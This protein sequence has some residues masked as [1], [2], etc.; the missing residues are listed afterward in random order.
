LELILD[1]AGFGNDMEKAGIGNGSHRKKSLIDLGFGCGDQIIHLISNELLRSDDVD[2]HRAVFSHYVGVTKDAV[3]AR[4]ASKRVEELKW[5][6]P[7]ASQEKQN[8]SITL[9][10]ADAANPKSWDEQ[11]QAS[12]QTARD[13][14]EECW[15]LALDTAY[16]FSPSRWPLI[17]Y[18]HS[19]LDAS[20]MG[21]DL[22]ISPTATLS[23]KMILRILTTLMGA[24]WANFVTP[25]EYGE[26]LIHIGYKR[27]AIA[28]KDISEHVFTPLA[29]FLEAQDERLKTLGL[30]L[31]SFRVAKT[32]F[33][34]WGRTGVVR[35]IV[36]VARK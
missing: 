3:Q 16:H 21:F 6:V 17:S 24:P 2:Q 7:S 26:N 30:G 29:A 18:A 4:C 27:D 32:M 25:V 28:V 35:G 1:E 23:Q 20:F 31:G 15:V 14:S 5:S 11:L 8:S 22:C 36:A 9:Y 33:A 10:C 13:N 34:W 19:N 12:V